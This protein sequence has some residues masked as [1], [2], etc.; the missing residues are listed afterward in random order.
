M[1]TNRSKYKI[2]QLIKTNNITP[3]KEDGGGNGEGGKRPGEGGRGRGRTWGGGE[4][5]SASCCSPL[6]PPVHTIE[7]N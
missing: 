7:H 5:Y 2:W 3:Y 4:L 1:Y 6:A